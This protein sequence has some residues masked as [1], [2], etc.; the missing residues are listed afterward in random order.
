[1]PRR[2]VFRAKIDDAHG[3]A[4][5]PQAKSSIVTPATDTHQGFEMN[6][7]S[8]GS[9]WRAGEAPLDVVPTG[10]DALNT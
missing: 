10:E 4:V 5:T 9:Q 1:M 2:L 7:K 6:G 8:I 3:E